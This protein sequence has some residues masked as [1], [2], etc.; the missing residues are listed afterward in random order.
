VSDRERRLVMIVIF[1]AV[2]AAAGALVELIYLAVAALL[3]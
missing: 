1:V 2:A 3:G